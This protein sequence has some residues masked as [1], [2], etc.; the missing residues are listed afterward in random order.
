LRAKE[1][2]YLAKIEENQS[3]I[4]KFI[5]KEKE[6]KSHSDL[7]KVSFSYDHTIFQT[8]LP[9]KKKVFFF[10]YFSL[11]DQIRDLLISSNEKDE[12]MENLQKRLSVMVSSNLFQKSE[13]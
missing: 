5:E 13:K 9:N 6:W 7:L 12:K 2:E 1:F 11:K 3:L 10:S 4:A 8:L